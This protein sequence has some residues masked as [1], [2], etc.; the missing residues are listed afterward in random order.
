GAAVRRYAQVDEVLLLGAGLAGHE[1][2]ARAL[3][4]GRR[5]GTAHDL[6][7]AA[8]RHADDHVALRDAQPR[9]AASALLE[10][11]L[12]AFA[13]AEDGILTARHDRVHQTGRGPERRRH[14]GRLDDAQPA[15]RAGPDEDQAAALAQRLDDNLDAVG[16][17]LALAVD[18]RDDLAILGDEEIDDVEH[19]HAIDAERVRIDRFSWKVLPLRLIGH[20]WIRSALG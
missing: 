1:D 5:Q 18:R 14:L 10:V 4:A 16:D 3:L 19:R 12:G 11:V 15:A 17:A 6:R 7:H 9:D 2:D 8:G 20:A 13:R